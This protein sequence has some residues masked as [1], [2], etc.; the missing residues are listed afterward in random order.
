MEVIV[1]GTVLGIS[2]L[3]YILMYIDL[4]KKMKK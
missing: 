4:R 2:A 1:I 3:G